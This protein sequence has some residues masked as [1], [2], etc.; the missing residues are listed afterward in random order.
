MDENLSRIPFSRVEEQ[1]IAS[2]A[3][4]MRFMA[5]VGIVGGFMLLF[6]AV[7]GLGLVAMAQGLGDDSP[8]WAE[9][10]RS[11]NET[12][13]VLYALLAVFLL[14][15]IV[16]LWQNFALYR[17]G[18]HFHAVAVTDVADLE[19]LSRGLDRLRIY[20]KVQ[21]LIVVVTVATAFGAALTLVALGRHAS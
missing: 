4:W 15:A 1:T 16:S 3:R 9:R 10:L 14:A 18:D 13:G 21:V 19:Y 5:V 7:L 2:M 17:A 11:I 8:K 20:F 12:G 6:F